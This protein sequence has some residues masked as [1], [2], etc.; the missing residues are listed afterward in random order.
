VQRNLLARFHVT[1]PSEFF[2]G[3]NFWEVPNAPDDPDRGLKQPPY[4]LL[5][6][7]PT[8]NE[9]RFQLTSALTP[10]GRQNLAAIIS[11][12]YLDGRPRLEVLELP[13]QTAVPGPVQIHQ[14][15]TNIAE[16]RQQLNLLS[17][18]QAQVQYGNLL[19]LPFGDG[20]LYVEPVYVKS[21]QENAYPLLQRVLLAYGETGRYVVLANTLEAGIQQLLQA[22]RQNPTTPPP[23][24][25]PPAPTPPGTPSVLTPELAEAAARVQA[26]MNEV[27][28][29]QTSGNFE[30]YGKALAS[31]DTAMK[32]FDAALRAARGANGGTPPGPNATPTPGRTP[33]PT[34]TPS[35]PPG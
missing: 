31:L 33:A 23:G 29:A 4:Y 34:G 15:M 27:R 9:A 35:P 26:A 10:A 13:N 11:G 28:A 6:K 16:I 8:Q 18:N 30:R 22:G 24:T 3:Q 2:S 19:S 21:N 32:E 5:T 25:P 17:S 1:N 20:M 12:S 7:L 14:Q